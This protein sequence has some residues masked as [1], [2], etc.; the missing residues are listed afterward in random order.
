M[1]ILIVDDDM[2][3]I[4]WLGNA[5]TT[6][7]KGYLVLTATTA[8]QGL[9]FIKSEKPE[10]IIMDVRLG[11]LSGMALLEDY[12]QHVKDYFPS[13]IVISAYDDEAAKKRSEALKVDAFLLKPFH[14]DV[15]LRETLR[16]IKKQ[17]ETKLRSVDLALKGFEAKQNAVAGSHDFLK[18]RLD[19]RSNTKK[20]ES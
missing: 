17:L 6:L 20:E 5:F 10:V 13:V 3:V 2:E 12:S 15:L 9:N 4:R 18:D 11:P 7:L 19:K 16:A 8:N 1:K 14:Q